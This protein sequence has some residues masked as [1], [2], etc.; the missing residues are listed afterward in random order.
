[1]KQYFFIL[2]FIFGSVYSLASKPC[3]NVFTQIPIHLLRQIDFSGSDL[4]GVNLA[5]R[6]LQGKDFS[7]SDLEGAN[8]EGAYLGAAILKDANL[9]GANLESAIFVRVN[10]RGTNLE[11]TN[12]KRAYFGSWAI[13]DLKTKF[14]KG[15]DPKAAGMSLVE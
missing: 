3:E 14:P 12:L 5:R 4:R 2:F 13:Y 11:N 7:G 15:F 9:Q 8:L 10:F 6:D 1:M